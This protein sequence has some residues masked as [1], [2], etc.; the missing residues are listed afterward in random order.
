MSA[1]TPECPAAPHREQAAAENPAAA[2]GAK[3]AAD[4]D[5]PEAAGSV[6][7]EEPGTGW[8]AEES[9]VREAES[10]AKLDIEIRE[11]IGLVNARLRDFREH[12]ELADPWGGY[13]SALAGMLAGGTPDLDLMSYAACR[14]QFGRQAGEAACAAA[15]LAVEGAAFFRTGTAAGLTAWCDLCELTVYLH[16][17]IAGGAGAKDLREAIA[18]FAEDCIPDVTMALAEWAEAGTLQAGGIFLASAGNLPPGLRRSHLCDYAMVLD[19]QYCELYSRAAGRAVRAQADPEKCAERLASVLKTEAEE[20]DG[21]MIP[22]PEQRRLAAK[23]SGAIA[24]GKT[25]RME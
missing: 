10:R 7:A 18:W 12:P 8:T 5:P 17:E 6:P 2:P 24:C 16:G 3:P 20:K 21:G 19:A 13:F 1:V 22:S 14:R 23:L 9:R 15:V 11:R 25:D 4:Q